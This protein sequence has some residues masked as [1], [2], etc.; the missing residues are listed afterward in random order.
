MTEV[1]WPQ[2]LALIVLIGV[3]LGLFWRPRVFRNPLFPA[4]LLW[5]GGYFAFLAYHNNLQPRYYLVVAVPISV[6][7]AL[8][9]TIHNPSR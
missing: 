3:S 6:M 1:S 9:L 7:V 4:L 5:A 2:R 8:G